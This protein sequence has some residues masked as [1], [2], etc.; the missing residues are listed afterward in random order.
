MSA[1]AARMTPLAGV[2]IFYH[3]PA[4]MWQH[5]LM[6][7][8]R[9]EPVRD[10]HNPLNGS[11]LRHLSAAMKAIPASLKLASGSLFLEFGV[12]EGN[13]IRYLSTRNKHLQFDGF[14][15][16]EGL[17]GRA[18]DI[19]AASLGWKR[20]VFATPKPS[21]PSNVRL[22]QGFFDKTFAPFLDSL[23]A[24][25]R[26][27]V[28]FA[29][30]DADLYSSTI[31]V[32]CAMCSRCLLGEGTVLAFDE[33]YGKFVHALANHEWRALWE[34]ALSCGFTF[35]FITW[36][37]QPGPHTKA[38]RAAVQITDA[39]PRCVGRRAE[40]MSSTAR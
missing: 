14:D 18:S 37:V 28:A 13:S 26:T 36:M 15:S 32:L 5:Y 12:R 4:D 33:L 17:P 38:A 29:H 8:T 23:P 34:A 6:N 27:Q 35:R 39:G 24:S 9:I 22:H 30:L 3:N 31:E 7:A 40:R 16:W 19:G 11:I 10:G 21:V 1:C 2:P 25:S 20:G